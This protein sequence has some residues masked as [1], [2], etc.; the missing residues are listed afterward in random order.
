MKCFMKQYW[1]WNQNVIWHTTTWAIMDNGRT[2][3]MMIWTVF[4][5]NLLFSVIH[6]SP[7]G[8][9]NVSWHIC[10][11]ST[12]QHTHTHIHTRASKTHISFSKWKMTFDLF[13]SFSHCLSPPSPIERDTF[14]R[15]ESILLLF[16]QPENVDRK[17]VWGLLKL[18][19]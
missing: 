7:E 1:I 15:N 19:H 17:L 2:D 5:W 18:K 16:K 6:K 14:S 12:I 11:T 3:R 10:Y 13:Y 8:N 4:I 9:K